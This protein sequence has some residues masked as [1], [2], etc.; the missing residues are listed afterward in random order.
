MFVSSAVVMDGHR[1]RNDLDLDSA[2][3]PLHALFRFVLL[4]LVK[5]GQVVGVSIRVQNTGDEVAR[6]T[7][8]TSTS[9][10]VGS[11]C[12][13]K[14]MLHAASPWRAP[15]HVDAWEDRLKT[16]SNRLS[17]VTEV[18]EGCTVTSFWLR[19]SDLLSK[20]PGQGSKPDAGWVQQGC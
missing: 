18:R 3:E 12:L 1:T 13:A 19:V 9:T 16:S 17:Q 5:L 15:V 7:K 4:L 8:G 11:G 2:F 6:G 14:E 10:R 20:A